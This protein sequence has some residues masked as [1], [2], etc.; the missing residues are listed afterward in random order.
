MHG[1]SENQIPEAEAKK[2]KFAKYLP[3]IIGLVVLVVGYYIYT[4]MANT[5][6]RFDAIESYM[7]AVGG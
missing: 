2:S 7:H 4:F 3:W 1:F 5:N 6:A